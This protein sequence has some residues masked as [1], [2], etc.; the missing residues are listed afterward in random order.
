MKIVQ[1]TCVFPPY[2]GGI[3][4]AALRFAEAAAAL[5]ND[6]AVIT[7]L[8][9]GRNIDAPD[10][11][12]LI[13]LKPWLRYGNAA[14]IPQLTARLRSFDIV[15]LHYPFYGGAEPVY[16]A[17][18]SYAAGFKLI[19]HYHMDVYGL[20]WF[21][22]PLMIPSKFFLT[23][24][25]KAADQITGASID[26]LENSR[27]CAEFN[28]YRDKFRELPFSV[29]TDI[30][31]PKKTADPQT[32]ALRI[33]FVGGLDKAHYFKGLEVLLPALA[34]IKNK[35]WTLDIIGSGDLMPHYAKLAAELGIDKQIV[36]RG[37]LDSWKLTAAYRQSDLLVLPSINSNEAFGIV[38][39][40]ALASG[41][42][43]IASR[44]PGVR[45]VFEDGRQG[46]LAEPKNI[47]D[48]ADKIEKILSDDDKRQ[49]MGRQARI[50]AE[51]R[52]SLASL[53]RRLADIYR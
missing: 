45:T 12:G 22:R 49:A 4:Q 24:L 47:P 31:F 9:R 26:Y 2:G 34:K 10:H 11:V 52:Y 3:G 43:V 53:E 39:L 35:A 38:L 37:N 5:G 20:P 41:I 13:G 48:L 15:H 36:F 27:I 1:V 17:K 44:L 29:D 50:L 6:S 51:K 25:L 19:V 33:L 32:S 28:R 14:F 16:W 46:Y 7:P 42:P 30:F 8:Y 40:E 23:P 18:I 21:I